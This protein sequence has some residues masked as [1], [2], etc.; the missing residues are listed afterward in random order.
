MRCY[1]WV[2]GDL[3]SLPYSVIYYFMVFGLIT[4]IGMFKMILIA[5]AGGFLGTV[6]RFLASRYFQNL[7]LTSF[8]LGTFIVNIVGCLFI[9]IFY[10]LA[11]KG[12]IL[13]P[14][15]R[16]FL[17][18]GFCGGFTTFSTFAGENI[19]LLRDGNIFYF[20]LYTGLSVFIGLLATWFGHITIIKAF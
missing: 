13:S 18:V 14:E 1:G 11:E 2:A 5:G 12:D 9:G 17:T 8:P 10:G 19:A 16:I 3:L 4:Q 7:L 20:S 6:F 15:L